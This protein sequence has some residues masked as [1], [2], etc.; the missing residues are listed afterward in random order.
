MMQCLLF[1]HGSGGG[2]DLQSGTTEFPSHPFGREIAGIPAGLL[3]WA[4]GALGMLL[5]IVG[6]VFLGVFG[7]R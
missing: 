4:L 3:G 6:I 1:S 5:I 7:G 2:N